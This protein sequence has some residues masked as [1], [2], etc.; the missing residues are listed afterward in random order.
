ME[1]AGVCL[2]YVVAVVEAVGVPGKLRTI[3][4]GRTLLPTHYTSI[5]S[6]PITKI[7]YLDD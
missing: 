6:I 4:Q 5:Q 1:Q 2:G 3:V 7:V